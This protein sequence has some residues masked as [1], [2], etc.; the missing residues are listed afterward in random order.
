MCTWHI[1]VEKGLC[2]RQNDFPFQS[3]SRT[4][5]PQVTPSRPTPSGVAEGE[6][7]WVQMGEHL[8]DSREMECGGPDPSILHTVSPRELTLLEDRSSSSPT[9][10]RALSHTHSQDSGEM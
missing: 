4:I 3:C 1:S 2:F 10:H 9:E 7:G 6:S 8:E 5:R